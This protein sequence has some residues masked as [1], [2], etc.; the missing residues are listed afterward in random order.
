MSRINY[1]V[2][3]ILF[4]VS[5]QTNTADKQILPDWVISNDAPPGYYT[6]VSYGALTPDEALKRAKEHAI[7]DIMDRVAVKVHSTKILKAIDKGDRV[8]I[9]FRKNIYSESNGLIYGIDIVNQYVA[10]SEDISGRYNAYV[11]LFVSDESIN[12]A[13]ESIIQ[14]KK[15]IIEHAENL[16]KEG[17]KLEKINVQ[18]ALYNYHEAKKMISDF[19]DYNAK[20]IISEA[21]KRIAHIKSQRTAYDIISSVES[22]WEI[23]AK[24]KPIDINGDAFQSIISG[25]RFR[26][27][28]TVSE[29]VYAYIFAYEEERRALYLIYPVST[30]NNCTISE[31]SVV[32][33]D[34]YI[35]TKDIEGG[36]KIY[37][38]LTEEK[39]PIAGLAD[40]I[41]DKNSLKEFL[42]SL[43]NTK[44]K[45]LTGDI[46]VFKDY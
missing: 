11:Q 40:K 25:R 4:A 45:V 5:C 39:M 12:K 35:K 24:S 41:I 23:N 36:V 1:F 17:R 19:D 2:L 26:F 10:P 7:G 32:P 15:N 22:N 46:F 30:Y 28:I 34:Y 27:H 14:Q 13:R 38:I 43:K 8:D 16:I 20:I 33:E 6:G 18:G 3:L 21:D 9:E 44:Y 31:N 29:E 42:E 37:L